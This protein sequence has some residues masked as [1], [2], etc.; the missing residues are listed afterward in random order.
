MQDLREIVLQ[1]ESFDWNKWNIE[2]NLIKHRVTSMECE[3]VF[4]NRPFL[5]SI[6]LTEEKKEQRIYAFGTTD[7]NRKITIVFTIRNN[8]IRVIS[9]R[10]MSRKER[11]I[12]EKELKKSTKI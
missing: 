8:K 10:D 3:E 6:P 1:I 11:R 4:L 5:K 9:A 12:Y 2:K 7:R